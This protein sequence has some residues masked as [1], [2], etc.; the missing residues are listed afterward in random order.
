MAREF[1]LKLYNG[2][3]ILKMIAKE[4]GYSITGMDWWDTDDAKKFMAE[5][6]ANLFFDKKVDEALLKIMDKENAVITSYTL[7]WLVNRPFLFKIWLK[8]SENN[9]AQRMADRDGIRLDAAQR[10]IKVRDSENKVIYRNLYGFDFG[11]DLTVFD[12][13][14]NTDLINLKSLIEISIST[15]KH[16]LTDSKTH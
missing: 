8:G 1:G 6:K 4:K 11:S 14:L 10:I 12:F 9:R 13:F 16:I 5:R 3:D 7:P 15:I 2:G